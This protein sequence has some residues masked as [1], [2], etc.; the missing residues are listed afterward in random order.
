MGLCS[1]NEL[2]WRLI[3]ACKKAA[4]FATVTA[5]LGPETEFNMYGETAF[6]YAQ[7]PTKVRRRIG[8]VPTVNCKPKA[9]LM[10]RVVGCFTVACN[11]HKPH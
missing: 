3:M 9:F 11:R 2:T 6:P 4:T 7:Y 1:K 10:F 5:D 8:K